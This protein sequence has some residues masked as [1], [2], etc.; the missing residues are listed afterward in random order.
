M[1]A[2]VESQFRRFLLATAAATYLAAA[3][4]LVLVDHYEDALQFIPFGLIAAGLA[5][6][7]WAAASPS[8][9]ALRTLQGVG[10]LVVLGS[11]VGI[12][13]HVKG[14]VEF[15]REIQ[16]D[17][18]LSEALWDGLD[19]GNPFLA[20]GMIA[21]AGVLAAAASYRHPALTERDVPTEPQG[22]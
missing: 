14:N 20:P 2:T 17:L 8:R 18:S 5:A 10:A 16:P 7:A 11:L 21:L 19:G 9:A 6:A 12:V 15:A 13:L 3:V 4:E 1:A 22:A